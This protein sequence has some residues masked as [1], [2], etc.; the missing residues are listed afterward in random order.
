M[1]DFGVAHLSGRQA[2]V[3]AGSVKEGMRAGRPQMI[4]RRCMGLS[5]GVIGWILPPSPAVHDHEHHRA[6]F[7]HADPL[8]ISSTRYW[9]KIP[10]RR[11]SSDRECILFL[12]DCR[13]IVNH[14]YLPRRGEIRAIPTPSW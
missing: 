4:E 13:I 5:D 2:N 1:S 8:G 10:P 11:L 6:I 9:Q 12:C 3:L 14:G 7:L